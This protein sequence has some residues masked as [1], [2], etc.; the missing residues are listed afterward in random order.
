MTNTW[1]SHT[2]F[3][4]E[5]L[6]Q[7]LTLQA[8]NVIYT[9]TG[10]FSRKTQRWAENTEFFATTSG[11]V[12][13]K[14]KAFFLLHNLSGNFISNKY[15]VPLWSFYPSLHLWICFSTLPSAMLT[16]SLMY[17]NYC[18]FD[19]R[20]FLDLVHINARLEK[21]RLAFFL[22]IYIYIYIYMYVYLHIYVPTTH[23]QSSYTLEI[24]YFRAKV[25]IS[26]CPCR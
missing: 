21:M 19:L 7:Q 13:T 5:A 9:Q 17:R 18:C 6:F 25:T 26:E 10:Q 1:E 4:L 23:S 20:E 16:N 22:H 2:A 3:D 12:L 14:M 11:T 15:S 24:F 8:A